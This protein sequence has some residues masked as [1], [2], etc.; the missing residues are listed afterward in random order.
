[1]KGYI[2]VTD[3]TEWVIPCNIAYYD[4]IG[5]FNELKNIEWKQSKN[6]N[7]NDIVYIYVGNPYKEIKYKCIAKKVDLTEAGRIDDS[8]FI[9]DDDNY[10]STGRYMELELIEKYDEQQLPLSILRQNGVKSVQGPF[11][12]GRELSK[13]IASIDS[14]ANYE[15]EVIS[16]PAAGTINLIYRYS[17]HA[18]PND[19]SRYP[20][21]KALFYTFREKNGVMTRLYELNTT[22]DLNPEDVSKLDSLDI[23]IFIKERIRGYIEDRKNSFKFDEQGEYKFYILSEPIYLTNKVSLPKQNNHSYFTIDEIFSGREEIKRC[24][25]NTN[26]SRSELIDSIKEKSK[27]HYV[28]IDNEDID[29]NVELE[30][31][32]VITKLVKIKKRNALA[33]KL[34]IENFKAINGRVYCEVCGIEDEVVL[35][36][37]HDKVSVAEMEDGHVTKLE[38]LRVI[39]ANCHRKV[40]GNKITVDRL[41][42]LYY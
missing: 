22:L 33:R 15:R 21:K 23:D 3:T 38:D 9:I 12:I 5:A 28:E 24:N 32:E 37:H 41:R 13:Y 2:E 25:Y 29:L 26:R 17:I 11:R 18:H 20:Y 6:I 4:V 1:M 40:H 7:V 27:I 31:G 35:D 34:K 30:E 16:I 10:N 39:C 19:S 8:K 42:E 36:V 14:K